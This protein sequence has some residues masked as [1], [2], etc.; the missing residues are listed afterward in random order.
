MYNNAQWLFNSL[1]Y[2]VTIFTICL[3]GLNCSDYFFHAPP[4][5]VNAN[6]SLTFISRH[7]RHRRWLTSENTSAM[8]FKTNCHN[9]HIWLVTG[10]N[11]H[12]TQIWIVS[13][14]SEFK[15]CDKDVDMI[16]D[17]IYLKSE[18]CELRKKCSG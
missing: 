8:K 17:L 12:S 2:V 6:I 13:A 14:Y 15:W 10:S 11:L 5:T 1:I 18:V 7:K 4:T 9:K 16:W 3:K